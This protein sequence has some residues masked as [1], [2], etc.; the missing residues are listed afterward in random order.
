MAPAIKTELTIT[1]DRY[2]E[3]PGTL[4]H[5]NDVF[6]MS[7]NI[8]D[9]TDLYAIGFTINY[10]PYGRTLTASPVE[11]GDFLSA[12][13]TV[14]TGFTYKI[15]IFA[16]TI[17]VGITR[18]GSVPGASG[19]GTVAILKFTVTEAGACPITITDTKL[20]D[21]NLDEMDYV[22]FS[23]YYY[24]CTADLI[25]CNM[26]DGRNIQVGTPA[27]FQIR[28]R[29]D[30]D[31]PMTVRT[32]LEFEREEDGRRIRLYG[33]QTYYG[34]YLGAQPPQL[35]L[36][37]DGWNIWYEEWNW[38]QVV[39]NEAVGTGDGSTTTFWLAN[40]PITEFDDEHTVYLDTVPQTAGYALDCATGN[41]TFA[42]APGSGVAITADYTYFGTPGANP[43]ILDEID[44]NYVHSDVASA[45]SSLYTFEDLSPLMPYLGIYEVISNVDFYGY[46]R[47][48]KPDINDIDPYAFTYA[49]GEYYDF[50]WVDSWGQ[51]MDWSW[52]G[53]KHYKDQLDFPEYYGYP[54][55][56]ESVDNTEL[57]LYNY[58][59]GPDGLGTWMSVDAAKML[60]EFA[61]IIPTDPECGL[62]VIEPG[63]EIELDVVT[64]V[65]VL[66]HVGKYNVQCILEYSEKYTH[67]PNVGYHWRNMGEKV[68]TFSFWVSE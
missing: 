52:S 33:G 8:K 32:R 15:D 4:G 39:E 21:S 5:V 13:G 16:G 19:S 51:T 37:A 12:G 63:E 48:E 17:K 14:Y 40:T 27:V 62:V 20:L 24:G 38:T 3:Q 29:N 44:G 6:Y 43:H 53:L 64:W 25:R 35:E 54:L 55:T 61:T 50:C 59:G 22:T 57:L 11:E 36:F 58:V 7:V 67:D 65:P 30:G 9:V 26:P 28:A 34:G 56:P 18:L 10:A 60:V 45:W 1:P 2:P 66:D 42:V 46:C 47:I 23:S 49:D 68:R 41:L 31:V